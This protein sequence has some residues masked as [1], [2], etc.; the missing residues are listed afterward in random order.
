MREL[1]K[2]R[3]WHPRFCCEKEWTVRLV[4]PPNRE[5]GKRSSRFRRQSFLGI[6]YKNLFL[7]IS[8]RKGKT[9]CSLHKWNEKNFKN[10]FGMLK[11][12]ILMSHTGDAR[13][14]WKFLFFLNLLS[15]T[16]GLSFPSALNVQPSPC[17]SD[18]FTTLWK[19]YIHCISHISNN[20]TSTYYSLT[21]LGTIYISM[22][23]YIYILENLMI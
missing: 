11:R 9:L 16:F 4:T 20:I 8:V 21:F 12:Y 19:S 14:I 23:L 6:S 10:L 7:L 13:N 2:S 15:S 3:G 5:N 18:K 17:H 22:Y 1:G